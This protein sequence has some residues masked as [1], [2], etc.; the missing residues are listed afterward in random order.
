MIVVAIIGILAAIAIPA[1]QDYTDPRAG[2]RRSEPRG[3]GLKASVAGVLPGTG[4]LPT[5][6]SGC[7]PCNSAAT[8]KVQSITVTGTGQHQRHDHGTVQPYD[9]A[10]A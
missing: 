5:D 8:A 2:D 7:R 1:Y 3:R 10:T 4:L 6:N 9:S